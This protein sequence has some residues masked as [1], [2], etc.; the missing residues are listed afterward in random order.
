M[1]RTRPILSLACAALM[2]CAVKAPPRAA[3]IRFREGCVFFVVCVC[4]DLLNWKVFVSFFFFFSD[5]LVI[6]AVLGFKQTQ[7][8][9]RIRKHDTLHQWSRKAILGVE[10]WQRKTRWWFQLFNY[11]LCSTLLGE[12]DA[13]IWQYF[14]NR[15]GWFNHQLENIMVFFLIC[16]F[17]GGWNYY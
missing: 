17:W 14:D 10:Q 5:R 15:M 6:Y 3:V 13:P 1:A 2:L 16:F 8:I 7:W 9:P 11:S 4:V 12:I